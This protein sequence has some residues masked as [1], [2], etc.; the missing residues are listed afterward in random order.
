MVWQVS[1]R[2][3]AAGKVRSYSVSDVL[4]RVG[5]LG[6]LCR[7]GVGAGGVAPAPPRWPGGGVVRIK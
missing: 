7:C 3:S 4:V 1:Y 2:R 5:S 6:F